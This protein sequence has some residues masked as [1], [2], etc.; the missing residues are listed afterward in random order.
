MATTVNESMIGRCCYVFGLI[1][2]IAVAGLLRAPVYAPAVSAPS[3][4]PLGALEATLARTHLALVLFTHAHC[5][6]DASALFARACAAHSTAAAANDDAGG[7]D[8]DSRIVCS[9]ITLDNHESSRTLAASYGVNECPAIVGF[10]NGEAYA[11]THYRT[12]RSFASLRAFMRHLVDTY[13]RA[14]DER[15]CDVAALLNERAAPST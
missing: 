1:L 2:L 14:A 11:D 9:T 3:V 8:D 6:Y 15:T 10:V 5:P 12:G 7:G 13:A 4:T